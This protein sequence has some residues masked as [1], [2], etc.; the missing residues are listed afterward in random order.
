MRLEDMTKCLSLRI[1]L[2]WN[3]SQIYPHVRAKFGH[4]R[5]A[6]IP[7]VWAV[8]GGIQR[9]RHTD[10]HGSAHPRTHACT[11]VH[12]QTHTDTQTQQTHATHTHTRARSTHT[13]THAR[14]HNGER[15]LDNNDAIAAN[16]RYFGYAF[17]CWNSLVGVLCIYRGC[18]T[19][20]M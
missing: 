13:H 10:T 15:Q 7:A 18:M 4:D 16:T 5:K 8:N 17:G 19:D 11:H 12:T 3:H 9:E 1:C 2:W 14:T 20:C 6:Y